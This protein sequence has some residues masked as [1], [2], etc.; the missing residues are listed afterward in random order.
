[1]LYILTYVK[2]SL[3]SLVIFKNDLTNSYK[4]KRQL[5]SL[6]FMKLTPKYKNNV[7]RY[8]FLLK[9]NYSSNDI[10]LIVFKYE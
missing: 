8:H 5:Y 10:A 9:S 3:S 1:M 2:I 6:F 7:L 4:V